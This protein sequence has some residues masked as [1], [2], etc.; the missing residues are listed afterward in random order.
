MTVREI[1]YYADQITI[2]GDST[3][4]T[5]I[6]GKKW[7]GYFQND[8][9][10]PADRNNNFWNFVHFNK[11]SQSTVNEVFNGKDLLTIE[12]KRKVDQKA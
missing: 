2:V 4:L 8:T 1:E 7:T 9:K 5:F 6:N 11:N 10:N 3:I 12:I